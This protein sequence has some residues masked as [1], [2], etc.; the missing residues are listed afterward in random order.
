MN[1]GS[2]LDDPQARAETQISARFICCPQSP[3]MTQGMDDVSVIDKM[4]MLSTRMRPP[5]AQRHQRRRAEDVNQHRTGTPL[6]R[7]SPP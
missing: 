2:P 4:A 5:A 6:Q 3:S 7:G 1:S